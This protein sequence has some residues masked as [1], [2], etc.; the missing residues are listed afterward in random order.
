MLMSMT[1]SRFWLIGIIISILS[2]VWLANT[3]REF[4]NQIE[5]MPV[6]SIVKVSDFINIAFLNRTDLYINKYLTPTQI[7]I[8]II[9][10]TETINGA[11]FHIYQ[12][13][14][15]VKSYLKCYSY[16]NKPFIHDKIIGIVE[17][18]NSEITITK[19]SDFSVYGRNSFMTIKYDSHIGQFIDSYPVIGN[20]IKNNKDYDYYN[21]ETFK[22]MPDTVVYLLGFVN[23]DNKF[24]YYV[25][26]KRPI[27]VS[28]YHNIFPFIIS[29]VI[30]ICS[31]FGFILF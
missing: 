17:N 4:Y 18:N 26:S 28:M 7:D 27:D 13:M 5:N 9:Y 19:N 30:F 31:V 25:I 22:F 15:S 10:G 21:I 14:Q 2:F 3:N 23:S 24:E 12:D 1:M 20:V 29:T 11:H 8:N 16:S 6:G